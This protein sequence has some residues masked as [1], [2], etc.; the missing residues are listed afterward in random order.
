M[1]EQNLSGEPIYQ[2]LDAALRCPNVKVYL[3]GK[4]ETRPYRKM[5]HFT[6]WGKTRAEVIQ[7]INYLKDIVSLTA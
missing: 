7:T 5:G 4:N 3:Y 1:W 2:E 6:V